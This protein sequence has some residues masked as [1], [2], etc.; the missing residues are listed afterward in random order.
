MIPLR[1]PR[2]QSAPVPPPWLD[3][4]F[5]GATEIV[6]VPLDRVRFI[7]G[8]A[9]G[10]LR[11][12]R[13]ATGQPLTAWSAFVVESADQPGAVYVYSSPLFALAAIALSMGCREGDPRLYYDNLLQRLKSSRAPLSPLL[14]KGMAD[15]HFVEA[16]LGT[17]NAENYVRAYF[18]LHE[19]AVSET[20]SAPKK[21]TRAG[22]VRN[23]AGQ[24]IEVWAPATEFIAKAVPPSPAA[25]AA[26]P[27]RFGESSA[28]R[29]IIGTKAQKP[30]DTQMRRRFN[31]AE[32]PADIPVRKEPLTELRRTP[33][34]IIGDG[35]PIKPAQSFAVKLYADL[36]AA[37]RGAETS[38]IRIV[39]PTELKQVMLMAWVMPSRHF[40]VQGSRSAPLR[41]DPEVAASE[42][43]S[44]QLVAEHPEVEDDARILVVF[45]YQGRPC[46]SVSQPVV[47]V[48]RKPADSA[49]P[50]PAIIASH[51]DAAPA[52]LEVLITQKGKDGR[53]FDCTVTCPHLME[54]ADGQHEP[55]ELAT[56]AKEFVDRQFQSFVDSTQQSPASRRANLRGVGLELFEAAPDIFKAAIWALRDKRI[57]IN[58]VNV[59]T[60]DP[61]LPWELMVP[62]RGK[63]SD[64]YPL[65]VTYAV[66]RCTTSAYTSAPRKI[67]LSSS[68]VFAPN[69]PE[70]GPD[71]GRPAPLA[72]GA[73]EAKFVLQCVPGSLIMPAIFDGVEAALQRQPASLLHFVCHGASNGTATHHLLCEDAT[74]L[75]Y[76]QIR[77]SKKIE[78]FCSANQ[79][80]VFLNACEVGRVALALNGSGGFASAF[81]AAGA[82]A[83]IAPLWSVDDSVA[84]MVAQEFYETAMADRQRPFADI[85]RKI[86]RKAVDGTANDTFAAYCF[87]GDPLAAQR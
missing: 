13:E 6:S 7:T 63:S 57:K 46:G 49:P 19:Y 65:G 47:L 66:G 53:F 28:R 42:V 58:S 76:T 35:S 5:V 32:S 82:A 8:G 14:A 9:Q 75:R 54:F 22:V 20:V 26:P 21:P 23:P 16:A 33:H 81:I 55:W 70:P 40:S 51:L 3:S 27:P 77:G 73:A 36:Q 4:N 86:R 37:D 78:Q 29:M 30:Q 17:E 84:H 83:V 24:V 43:I 11:F 69:Y 10:V 67:P 59:V 74:P 25:K 34:L 39:V 56:S 60:D 61:Y 38:D 48:G 12:L 80:L 2:F 18:D 41:I 87:Y 85:L 44:F 1:D 64:E 45:T 62:V 68:L 50:P 15:L 31:R 71:D 79:P 52:D 72:E